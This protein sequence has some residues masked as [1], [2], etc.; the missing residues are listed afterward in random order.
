MNISI[1]GKHES[2]SLLKRTDCRILC[3]ATLHEYH[4]LKYGGCIYNASLPVTALVT[5]SNNVSEIIEYGASFTNAGVK[6]LY[7]TIMPSDLTLLV[8]QSAMDEYKAVPSALMG[9][10]CIRLFKTSNGFATTFA[11]KEEHSVDVNIIG[12]P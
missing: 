12:R 4:S 11:T 8:K 7:K 9:M 3:T 2:P 1:L 6:P 5:M 10:F